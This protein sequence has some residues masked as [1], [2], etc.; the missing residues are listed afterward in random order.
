M[1]DIKLA[2]DGEKK[3]A[4]LTFPNGK[5]LRVGNVTESQAN[6]FKERHGQEFMKR[7]CCFQTM[8]GAFVRDQNGG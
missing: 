6:A 3:L 8:E 4:V 2:Y 5:E 1:S 7:D